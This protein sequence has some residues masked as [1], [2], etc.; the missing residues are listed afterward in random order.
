M[1][2]ENKISKQKLIYIFLLVALTNILTS[3]ILYSQNSI[4]SIETQAQAQVKKLTEYVVDET[5]T[6]SYSQRR[7]LIDK[8]KSFEDSTSNQ[9]VVYI[10][11]SLGGKAIEDFA[12]EIATKNQI[13]QKGKNNGVLFLI[14]MNDR[15]MRIEVGYGLEGALPDALCKRIIENEVKP[16]FQKSNYYEGILKGVIAIISA[17]KGEY[18]PESKTKSIFRSIGSVLLNIL[19][20][21]GAL[22][23]LF[24]YAVIKSIIGTVVFGSSSKGSGYYRSGGW[25]SRSG[26]FSGGG[27]SFGGGG[28]SGSW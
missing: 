1:I 8:L 3:K 7:I 14:A 5:N 22:V 17:T 4:D 21:I 11:N 26:G 13:G 18:K 10:I 2:R 20:F 25:S 24:V 9:V 6:L 16:E 19:I 28:A 12:H 27:G 15:K 23:L